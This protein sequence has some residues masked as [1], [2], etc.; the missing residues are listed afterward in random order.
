VRGPGCVCMRARARAA[1]TEG[2]GIRAV[3]LDPNPCP[4]VQ[5]PRGRDAKSATSPMTG[6]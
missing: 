5:G 6:K 3:Q 1:G 4:T 2:G